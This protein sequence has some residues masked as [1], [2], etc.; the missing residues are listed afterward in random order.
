M[1]EATP[2]PPF[3]MPEPDLLLQLLIIALDAPAQLGEIYQVA[4]GDILLKRREPIFCRLGL[5]FRPL[6][7][8]PFFRAALGKIV[9]AMATRIR[10]RAKREDNCSAEPSR[11]AILCQA[12]AGKPKASCLTEVGR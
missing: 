8:Q 3:E 1:V 2:S 6:D 10:N 12:L 5:T 4:E 9:I 11:H 7:Q